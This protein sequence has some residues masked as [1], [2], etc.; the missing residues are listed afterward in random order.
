MIT[1]TQHTPHVSS[2][3][4]LL[5][6]VCGDQVFVTT[7]HLQSTLGK[8]LLFLV[9]TEITHQISGERNVQWRQQRLDCFTP[10]T[11]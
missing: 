3:F 5:T 8:L 10:A 7:V 9:V 11:K 1:Q 6:V 2:T 4:T